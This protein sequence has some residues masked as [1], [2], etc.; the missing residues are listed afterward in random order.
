MMFLGKMS[1]PKILNFYNRKIN[2]KFQFSQ[3]CHMELLG[4]PSAQSFKKH[5]VLQCSFKKKNF[6][7]RK[8]DKM[9]FFCKFPI[10]PFCR[11]SSE[12]P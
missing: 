3:I 12:L 1:K 8:P 7:A 5:V 4:M 10:K 2:R 6:L 9:V 11:G